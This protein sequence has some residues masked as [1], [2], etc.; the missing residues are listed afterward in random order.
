MQDRI[1]KQY[2]AIAPYYDRLNAVDY[3]AWC[4][5]IEK[6]LATY[7][8]ASRGLPPERELLDLACGTG[9]IALRMA[10]RGYDVVGVDLSAEM[11]A[12]AR[13]RAEA[14][15]TPILLLQQDMRAFELYGTVEAALC[16]LDS[17][18]YLL[19]RRDWEKTFA[20]LHNYIEPQ[21]LLLFD[22]HTKACL[23]RF[24]TQDFVCEDDGVVLTWQN[25]YRASDATCDF[26]LS[27]F[28]EGADGRY[29][30]IE[31]HQRERAFSDRTIRDMLKKNGF[32]VLSACADL[33]GTP[34]TRD[35]DRC[36]YICRC[37][38]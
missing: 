37:E 16:C 20:L 38:K 8:K 6:Q 2:T 25:D 3:D 19:T 26:Y 9:A 4:D 35:D 18:N 21:G 12:V 31:E 5:F 33:L 36:F 15:R 27:F 34:C 17:M 1:Q 24:G 7:G 30:R 22:V 11:L 28:C 29:T 13:Q 10:Q 14:Q 32:A 23:Q